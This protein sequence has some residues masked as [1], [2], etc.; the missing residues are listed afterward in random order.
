MKIARFLNKYFKI[1]AIHYV[2]KYVLKLSENSIARFTLVNLLLRFSDKFITCKS[3]L[4]P[5]F[6]IKLVLC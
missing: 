3:D 1:K 4:N 5:T 2:S 6:Q